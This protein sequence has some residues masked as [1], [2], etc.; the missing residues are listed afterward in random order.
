MSQ[1]TTDL[2]NTKLIESL[3]QIIL[4]LTEE[5]RQLLAQTTQYLLINSKEYQQ[6]LAALQQ[7]LTLLSEFYTKLEMLRISSL[8][9]ARGCIYANQSWLNTLAER[10]RLAKPHYQNSRKYSQLGAWQQ[11]LQLRL[12]A[13]RVLRRHYKRSLYPEINGRDGETFYTNLLA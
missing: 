13:Y 6:Q 5:E 8:N 7:D 3:A 10:Y 9:R 1:K 11:H 12:L 2:I 4:S